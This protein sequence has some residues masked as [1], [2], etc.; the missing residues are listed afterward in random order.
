MTEQQRDAIAVRTLQAATI[1]ANGAI[2]VQATGVVIAVV[3]AVRY[4]AAC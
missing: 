4:L 1:A 2:R 3:L